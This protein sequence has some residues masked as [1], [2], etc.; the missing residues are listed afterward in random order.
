MPHTK[1]ATSTLPASEL[2]R[3]HEVLKAKRQEVFALYR[4]DVKVG[5]E[6]TDDN[7]DD[8]ADRANNSY[9]RE[10]MFALSTAERSMLF[11][12]DEALERVEMKTFGICTHCGEEIGA[13]RLR[14]VPW[15][16]YCIECQELQ[17]KG[18]LD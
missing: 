16:R 6:S 9:N 10:T 14:A 13:A 12:I 2:E 7:A 11:A 4:R 18:L 8:F 15:T 3:L 1:T 17:E 5:Q